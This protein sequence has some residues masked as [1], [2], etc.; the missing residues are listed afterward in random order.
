MKL[1]LLEDKPSSWGRPWWKLEEPV[2]WG[3]AVI[4]AGFE[5][6]LASVPRIFWP[7]V[8]PTNPKVARCAVVHDWMCREATSWKQRRFADVVFY[9]CL[10]K[11]GLRWRAPLMLLAVSL[12]SLWWSLSQISKPRQ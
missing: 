2:V 11:R 6:D 10:K 7:L 1:E 3:A 8:N 12:G 5:T 9:R 4:P